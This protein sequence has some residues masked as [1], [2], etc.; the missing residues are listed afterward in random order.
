MPWIQQLQSANWSQASCIALFS[1]L[2]GCFATGYYLVKW[3]TGRDLRDLGSGSLGARNVGRVLGWPGFVTALLGDIAKGALAV[4]AT[5]H[6]TLDDR[7]VALAMVSVVAGHIWPAQL[8]LHGGKGIATSLGALLI[9][10]YHLIA[11]FLV[12]FTGFL[13][14]L[15]KM[16]LPGLFAIACLPLVSMYLGDDSGKIVG[17]SMIAGLVLLAH[18][19]NLLE[20]S[21][22][23]VERR[24]AHAK[25][26][27]KL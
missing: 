19:K 5:R 26:Q 22:E 13:L 9:Y 18:R 8:W 14:V 17:I 6:Y 25:D 11:A 4:W 20:E 10:D 21:L 16:V 7:M 12:L 27:N 15:R 1:Y 2:L 3:R 23:F 24:K